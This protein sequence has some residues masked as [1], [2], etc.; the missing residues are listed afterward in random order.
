MQL[1]GRRQAVP[2]VR[3]RGSSGTE[4]AVAAEAEEEAEVEAKEAARSGRKEVLDV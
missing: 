4:A 2:A 3:G 1:R